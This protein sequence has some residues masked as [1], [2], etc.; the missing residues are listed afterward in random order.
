ME[1]FA[2]D[3]KR[4]LDTFTE[5]VAID[6]LSGHERAMADRLKVKLGDLGC[7]VREDNTGKVIGGSAGNVIGVLR[8]NVA[9]P[10]LILCA[11]MDTVTP[12]EGKQAVLTNGEIRSNGR[13]VLGADDAAGIAIILEALRVVKESKY[14]HPSIKVIFT[15][16]E[17]MGLQ[18]AKNI[19]LG[20]VDNTLGFVLDA[21]GPV[22]TIYVSAP[23]HRKFI[24]RIRGK[25]AHAGEEPEKGINAI[26]VAADAIVRMRLGRIDTETTANVGLIQGGTATN[27]VP[28]E[29]EIKGEIRSLKKEKLLKQSVQIE[30]SVRSAALDYGA[31]AEIEMVDNYDGFSLKENNPAVVL[32]AKA[33]KAVGLTPVLA[34]SGGGSDANILNA[35]GVPTVNLSIGMEA[36]HTTDEHIKVADMVLA[37]KILIALI[38]EAIVSPGHTLTNNFPDPS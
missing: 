33:V 29:V 21:G 35:K 22:G 37:A 26:Q 27:V 32:A 18:G 16:A 10:T 13:S 28:A 38:Q 23:F 3:T 5:L 25:A 14:S 6:S 11:H 34:S 19:D 36:V 31:H 8:G 4:L 24:A 30:E 7:L 12:G 20:L 1:I 9:G 17:E 15:V 2:V